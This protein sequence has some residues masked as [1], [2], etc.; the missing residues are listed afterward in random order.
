MVDENWKT[1]NVP[2]TALHINITVCDTHEIVTDLY[3]IQRWLIRVGLLA[4]VLLHQPH[5]IL[6]KLPYSILLNLHI[7]VSEVLCTHNMFIMTMF[8]LRARLSD[9][10]CEI[11]HCKITKA[12]R[13]REPAPP[14][15]KNFQRQWVLEKWTKKFIEF[16]RKCFSHSTCF[17]RYVRM[18]LVILIE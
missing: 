4:L 15:L 12:Q 3:I 16:K 11:F 14:T 1:R 13:I 10:K 17:K 7:P 8:S 5:Y 2:Q 18:L 9:A 6:S